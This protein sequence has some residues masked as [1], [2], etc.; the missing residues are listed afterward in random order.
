[1]KL[2][3]AS[4]TPLAGLQVLE[5]QYLSDSRGFLARIFC[6]EEL[7]TWGWDRPIAQIN[8]TST[9]HRGTIRGMHFQ[10]PPHAEMKLVKCLRGEIW[11][12][13]VDIRS[14]SPTFLHW[15]G[16]SLSAEN[17][18][19]LLI[20]HG[21]AH[22][23]QTTTNEVELLYCHSTAY[24]AGAEGGLNPQDPRLAIDWPLPITAMSDRDHSHPFIHQFFQGV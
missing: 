10:H 19:S 11:D 16:V 18:R 5:H 3:L 15:Y 20:P 24:C 8:H 9:L 14:D 13:V 6:A 23:F 21:F 17:R 1:M 7:A 12:V 4:T 2:F 22:G